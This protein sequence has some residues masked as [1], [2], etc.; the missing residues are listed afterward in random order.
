MQ[1]AISHVFLQNYW[2]LIISLT[3]AMLVLLM[4][5][6]GGQSF[7]FTLAKTEKQKTMIINTMGR[8]WESTFTTLVVFGGAFFASFPLFYA[9]SFG[10]A[11]WVWMLI[12]FSFVIQAIAFEYRSKPSNVLG[13]KT[14]DVFLL[15]NGTLSPLLIGIALATFF[16]GANF[17]L[18]ELNMGKWDTPWHGLEAVLNVRN[19]SLGVTV[20]FLT[21]LLGLLYIINT[22]D[23]DK[24]LEAA[25]K[26]LA[27][28]FFFFIAGFLYFVISLLLSEGFAVDPES[29]NIF[30]EKRKYLHNFLDMPLVLFMFLAG[31][32]LILFALYR[33]VYSSKTDPVW[34]SAAGTLLVVLSL[35]M[36]AGYNNTAFYPS[37]TDLQSS[38]TIRN[39][40]SSHFTL[41]VMFYVSFLIPVVLAYTWHAWKAINRF[42]VS[43][44]EVS[45]EGHSY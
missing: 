38:L 42:R 15:I 33:G 32:V 39:A 7:I 35:F 6:Q 30:M 19:I 4:F 9:V 41:K 29:G 27:T 22:I 21:R 18:N 23:D 31:T 43:E 24:L 20:L 28:N 37:V 14:F 44:E 2:W 45:G 17:S 25:R 11:Y 13:K 26:K 5:V 1:L 36:V 34:F 40:S 10:G 16:T 12:L 8:K 3:A